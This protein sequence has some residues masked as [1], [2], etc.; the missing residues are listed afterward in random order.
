MRAAYLVDEL[1]GSMLI[2]L[3]GSRRPPASFAVM[4]LRLQ[5]QSQIALLNTAVTHSPE[6]AAAHARATKYRTKDWAAEWQDHHPARHAPKSSTMRETLNTEPCLHI[7]HPRK[8]SAAHSTAHN[9]GVSMPWAA[10]HLSAYLAAPSRAR[11]L[12]GVAPARSARHCVTYVREGGSQYQVASMLAS[13]ERFKSIVQY[14]FQHQC[15]KSHR[16]GSFHWC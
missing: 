15:Q 10:V 2:R 3:H 14:T 13:L 8:P 7:R 4:P 1:R 16:W 11:I 5:T 6:P 12:V 9:S